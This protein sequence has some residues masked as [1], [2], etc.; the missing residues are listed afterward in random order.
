M[1]DIG[2][3]AGSRG[4]GFRRAAWIAPVLVGLTLVAG[5]TTASATRYQASSESGYLAFLCCNPIFAFLES[6]LCCGG[7]GNS[8]P[9]TQ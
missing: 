6:F 5:A 4:R 9:N 2:R 1:A 8:P 3:S 7:G